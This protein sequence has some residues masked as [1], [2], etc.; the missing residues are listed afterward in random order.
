VDTDSDPDGE[1]TED[2]EET[3]SDPDGEATED[4][5]ETDSE[6]DGEATED[7]VE[8]DSD[9]DGEATEADPFDPFDPVFDPD[10]GGTEAV[11]EPRR[12]FP[13]SSSTGAGVLGTL[14]KASAEAAMMANRV[15]VA[16]FMAVMSVLRR[17]K[18]ESGKMKNENESAVT[19]MR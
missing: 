19:K 13:L 11:Q 5:E 4:E 6:P 18:G 3:D 10:G 17:L 14:E 8:A 1:A 7:E 15:A 9:P 12:R 2:E 16:N